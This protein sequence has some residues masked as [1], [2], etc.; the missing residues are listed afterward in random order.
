MK[1][2]LTGAGRVFWA[3]ESGSELPRPAGDGLRPE[4]PPESLG[5]T[6]KTTCMP[7]ALSV[8][9]LVVTQANV[10]KQGH[11]GR[12]LCAVEAPHLQGA[13]GGVSYNAEHPPETLTS[14]G[15]S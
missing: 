6:L 12:L 4:S 1:G 10:W 11:A 3:P 15:G 9:F 8:L 13:K 2:A 14:L 5:V 7:Q